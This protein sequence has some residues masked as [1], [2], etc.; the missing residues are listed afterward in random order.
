MRKNTGSFE[1]RVNTYLVLI[2]LGL[3]SPS[4]VFAAGLS[5]LVSNMDST[6]ALGLE[7]QGI[8]VPEGPK[9]EKVVKIEDRFSGR[10]DLNALGLDPRNFDML[11][12][13]VRAGRGVF[14]RIS[15]ENYP[16]DGEL[17]HWYVL[18]AARGA[19]GWKTIWL[20]L[21]QPEEVKPPKDTKGMEK[22]D[23]SRRGMLL[24]GHGSPGKG[25]LWLG[26]MRFF[27]KPI[28]DKLDCLVLISYAV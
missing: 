9:S 13:E 11:K 18:D 26:R 10:I 1:V 17:S 7:G 2:C 25:A 4:A 15:L 21:R 16:N 19:F 8:V 22:K 6:K 23:L 5:K 14:M 28:L 12:F 27:K 3:M 20:D 24:S